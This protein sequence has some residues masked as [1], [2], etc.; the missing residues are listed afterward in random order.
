[1]EGDKPTT[2]N[3]AGGLSGVSPSDTSSS[4]ANNQ[5]GHKPRKEGPRLKAVFNKPKETAHHVL[6]TSKE[7]AHYILQTSKDQIEHNRWLF[8][9]RFVIHFPRHWPRMSAFLFGVLVPL[10]AMILVSMGF[11]ML[12]AQYEMPSEV[13]A[14]DSIVRAR[15]RIDYADFDQLVLLNVT[16]ICLSRWRLQVLDQEGN[17]TG[18]IR[19]IPL[20]VISNSSGIVDTESAIE[21]AFLEEVDPDGDGFILINQTLMK[22]ALLS[23]TD[24]FL[25]EL[26][27]FQEAFDSLSFNWI[28]CWDNDRF[29]K[30]NL[31][32]QP[33]D[34]MI[35]AAHPDSQSAYFEAEWTRMQ[36]ELY[37]QYLPPD[38][39][40]EDELLALL[41]S[42]EDATGGG[43]CTENMVCK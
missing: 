2:E 26:R 11:G 20:D 30:A 39:T 17:W 35:A 5:D 19:D 16:Q 7:N 8:P 12:L 6:E 37:Q 3:K 29:G 32:F 36:E 14:N 21:A 33:T 15:A 13:E 4:S 10:W 40:A 1:M 42:I 38:A 34:D 9:L 23:C 24:F 31:I 28:R 18:S 41:Q 43:A 22:N 27:K 25:P